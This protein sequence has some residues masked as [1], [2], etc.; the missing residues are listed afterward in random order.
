MTQLITRLAGSA[1]LAAA[2]AVPAMAQTTPPAGAPGGAAMPQSPKTA[3]APA[4]MPK[5]AMPKTAPGMATTA[6]VNTPVDNLPMT[7]GDRA[8]KIIGSSVTNE[9]NE[10][11][12]TVDDLI[13]TP[14]E[15]VPVAVLS[16]GGFLGMGTKYVAVPFSDLK[17]TA[18]GVSMPGATKESLKTL[19]EFKYPS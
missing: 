3:P 11:V 16:V 7:G 5:G 13:V 17:V 4:E 8:S 2:L 15:K 19:P 1:V 14:D 18:K 9:A 10:T 6:P 12:G